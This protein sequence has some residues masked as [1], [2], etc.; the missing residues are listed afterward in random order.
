MRFVL[1]KSFMRILYKTA[2]LLAVGV[3]WMGISVPLRGA[4]IYDNSQTDLDPPVRFNPA[5]L[6]VGN[7][8]LL[9]GTE[10][11]LTSFSFEYWAANTDTPIT[12]AGAVEARVRFYQN[13]G[14]LFNG[15]ACP[16][17]ANFFDSGW[18]SVSGPT[19]RSTFVFSEGSDFPVGGLFIP[20]DDITWTVQFEGLSGADSAGMDVY[21]PVAMGQTYGD[22]WQN[23]GGS[24]TLLTNTV[25][26][27]F[28]A[29]MD[30]NALIPE[31]STITLWI[32]GGL[33]I[34][35]VTRRL[36]RKE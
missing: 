6:E 28:A 31:P 5:T 3:L 33:G 14:A 19:D 29:K 4:T 15:Y 26:M 24:W 12:F 16:N 35:T 2:L 18:F 10:R 17:T 8:I 34:L 1:R 11:Y 23:D 30:A 32:F 13:T 25:P 27:N 20:A 21:G 36:H 22:Y 9:T 7:E